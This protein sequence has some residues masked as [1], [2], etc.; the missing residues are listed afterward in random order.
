VLDAGVPRAFVLADAL[1]PK[2][3]AA[4]AA[5]EGAK[6]LRLYDWAQIRLPWTCDSRFECFI[7]IRRNRRAPA[8]RAYYFCFVPADTALAELAGVAGLR[9]TIE[10]CFQW[11]KTDLGLDH[12]EARSWHGWHRHMSLVNGC[13]SLSAQACRRFAPRRSF[14]ETEQNESARNNCRLTIMAALAPSVPEIRD[15]LARIL[16]K[17]RIGMAFIIAWSL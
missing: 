4:H 17:P 16:F 8:E 7:L 2:A 10:E 5:G 3:W 12:C 1:D 11:A 9:W 15:L 6:G 13:G 14:R